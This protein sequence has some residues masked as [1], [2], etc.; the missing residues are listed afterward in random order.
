MFKTEVRDIEAMQEAL[1][2]KTSY[3]LQKKKF[4]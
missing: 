2:I 3:D 4:E 1:D